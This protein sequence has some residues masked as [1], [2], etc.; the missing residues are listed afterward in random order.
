[1]GIKALIKHNI[2]QLEKIP[3]SSHNDDNSA[4]FIGSPIKHPYEDDKFILI[5][6]PLTDHA[7]FIE[8]QKSD[9]L[10]MEE[11]SSLASDDGESVTIAKV[12]IKL[13]ASAIRYEPFVVTKT[14]D[15]LHSKFHWSK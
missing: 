2:L 9:I 15:I 11:L 14:K 3:F 12:F 7:M 13:G 5:C 6:D 10:F 8:F 4:L 1:M